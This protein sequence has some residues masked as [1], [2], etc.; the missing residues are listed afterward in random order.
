MTI[1]VEVLSE[2]YAILKQY[3][4][5]KDRQEAADALM[6]VLVDLLG[7]EELQDFTSTDSTLSRALKQYVTDEDNF[8]DLDDDH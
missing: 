7:D 5:T 3:L 8:E 4:P 6:S 2:T 1:D